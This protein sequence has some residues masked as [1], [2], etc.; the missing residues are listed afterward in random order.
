M[1]EHGM[2]LSC[3]FSGAFAT[4]YTEVLVVLQEYTNVGS[5]VGAQISAKWQFLK[6]TYF[7]HRASESLNLRQDDGSGLLCF[8]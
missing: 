2:S 4:N 5:G 1:F 3:D 7:P 8:P 6:I